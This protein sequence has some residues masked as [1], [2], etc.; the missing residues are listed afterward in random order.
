MRSEARKRRHAN[1][2]PG[3]NW[4]HLAVLAAVFCVLGVLAYSVAT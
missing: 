2:R 4:T 1:E 3:W